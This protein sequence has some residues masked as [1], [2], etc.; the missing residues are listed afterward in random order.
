MAV[1]VCRAHSDTDV[2]EPRRSGN[3]HTSPSRS[4]PRHVKSLDTNTVGFYA[5]T[6]T[7]SDSPGTVTPKPLLFKAHSVM[8]QATVDTITWKKK[9]RGRT[10]VVTPH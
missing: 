9:T 8:T 1:R 3:L 5:L 2:M 4:V 10:H 7:V 6:Y